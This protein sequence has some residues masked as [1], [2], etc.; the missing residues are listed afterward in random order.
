LDLLA[1]LSDFSTP[2][3]VAL[4]GAVSGF[5]AWIVS[6]RKINASVERARIKMMADASSGETADRVAFRTTLMAEIA[7]L[8]QLIKDCENEKDHLRER[9]NRTEGQILVLK[10]S[11]EIMEKWVAFFKDRNVPEVRLPAI[12]ALSDHT[13]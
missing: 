3:W 1:L 6:V 13:P 9:V 5:G 2:I 7:A 11:N 8:R 12:P 4:S 10:A